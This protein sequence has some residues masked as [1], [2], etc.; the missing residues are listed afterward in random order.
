[1][2]VQ[3]PLTGL[4]GTLVALLGQSALVAAATAQERIAIPGTSITLTAPPGFTRSRTARGIENAE[5]GSS[6]TVAER[7]AEAYAELAARFTSP[8]QLTE[9]YAAQGVTIRA[10]RELALA[11]GRVP[12]AV[13]TQR[14][15]T[16]DLVKYLALLQGDKTVLVTFNIANR[17]FSEADAEAVLQSID[18]KPAPT[19]EEQLAGLPFTFRTAEP[20]R[21]TAVR[22]RSSVTLGADGEGPVIVIGRGTSQAVSGEEPRVAVELLRNTGGFTDALITTQEARPFAGGTGYFVTAVVGDVTVAQYLRI[23]PGG[24]YLRFLAR[25]NT[26]AMEGAAAAIDEIAS[27]VALP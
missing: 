9:G 4:L 25:G 14:T 20:F 10:V 8:K 13:G 12:F 11:R 23:V 19:V 3:R 24:A 18:I 6:I 22:G 26:A 2:E 27:S 17:S 21:V 16:Q 15:D 7:P 5:T 1:M